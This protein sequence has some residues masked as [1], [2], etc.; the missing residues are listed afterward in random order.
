MIIAHV[1]MWNHV[2]AGGE[3]YGGIHNTCSLT[4]P[5]FF[6]LLIMQVS[7]TIIFYTTSSNGIS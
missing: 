5:F 7:L 3:H 1:K 6:L 4:H 2:D